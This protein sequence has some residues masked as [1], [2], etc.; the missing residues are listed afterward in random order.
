MAHTARHSFEMNDSVHPRNSFF[1][2][3]DSSHPFSCSFSTFSQDF[4]SSGRLIH[5]SSPVPP[6][7]PGIPC[8]PGEQSSSAAAPPVDHPPGHL[9]PQLNVTQ[10]ASKT[11]LSD[12]STCC[13][14]EGGVDS[15]SLPISP[16]AISSGLK[17]PHS[18]P[19]AQP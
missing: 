6:H 17:S 9:C 18:S 7:S 8:G 19:C 15:P 16:A 2:L 5:S 3:R 4:A 14:L 10:C 1:A 12:T 13:Q 11:A